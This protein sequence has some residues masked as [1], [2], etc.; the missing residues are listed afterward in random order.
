LTYTDPGIKSSK[1]RVTV[2]GYQSQPAPRQKDYNFAP[3]PNVSSEVDLE[4]MRVPH[5]GSFMPKRGVV[6][7]NGE[8]YELVSKIITGGSRKRKI[9]RM[10]GGKSIAVR[11]ID[12]ERLATRMARIQT[13]GGICDL[14]NV[15]GYIDESEMLVLVAKPVK[16]GVGQGKKTPPRSVILSVTGSLAE[17]TS[18]HF[19]V[20]WDGGGKLTVA[21]SRAE[22]DWD[23]LN[24]GQWIEATISRRITGEVVSALLVGTIE[25][26]KGLSEEELSDSYLSLPAADLDPME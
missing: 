6:E 8:L 16:K 20:N 4:V 14:S 26:P 2:A 1:F 22:G 15:A 3:R 9:L 11:I 24:V 25:E 13:S 7:L 21:R 17:K 23:Q 19:V 12:Y 18:K 5:H 10:A